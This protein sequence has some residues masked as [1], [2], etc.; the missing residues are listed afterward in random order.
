M[1]VVICVLC[2]LIG[3]LFTWFNMRSRA[4]SRDAK[5]VSEVNALRDALQLY[6]IDHG[7]YPTSTGWCSLESTCNDIL[8]KLAPYLSKTLKDPLYPQIQ[9]AKTFSYQYMSTSSGAGY[10]IH[11]DLETKNP[12]EVSVGVGGK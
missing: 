7:M 6:R 8:Q 9:G 5:R 4:Q 12:F 2:I 1:I 10:K 11:T 3:I